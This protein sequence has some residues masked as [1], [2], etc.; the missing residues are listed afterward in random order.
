MLILNMFESCPRVWQVKYRIVRN[1]LYFLMFHF[2]YLCPTIA[3]ISLASKEFK[4]KQIETIDFGEKS[5]HPKETKHVNFLDLYSFFNMS[6]FISYLS[7]FLSLESKIGNSSTTT[8]QSKN[9]AKKDK[10]IE[11][12]DSEETQVQTTF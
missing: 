11:V 5:G 1:L 3:A 12:P 2:I 7:L 10:A 6:F 8:T 4:K 9:K